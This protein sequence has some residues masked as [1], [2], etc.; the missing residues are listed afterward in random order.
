MGRFHT[1]W[2]ISPA[3]FYLR[4]SWALFLFLST[5][6]RF[7]VFSP[8]PLKVL[9]YIF[10]SLCLELWLLVFIL[11][12]CVCVCALTHH[13]H[14]QTQGTYAEVGQ[15]CLCVCLHVPYTR[16]CRGIFVELD[17][18]GTCSG[19]VGG[20][21]HTLVLRSSGLVG[22]LPFPRLA[23]PV[24]WVSSLAPEAVS[25]LLW[26]LSLTAAHGFGMLCFDFHL[27]LKH[28]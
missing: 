21:G 15:L 14:E 26:L 4:L 20:G 9:K 24:L 23:L 17:N 8:L 2:T 27:I 25:S 18:C 13:T 22:P 1:R 7:A 12:V 11:C 5:N 19:C 16:I 6:C 3:P 10:E 28:S